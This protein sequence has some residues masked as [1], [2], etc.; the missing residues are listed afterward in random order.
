MFGSMHE[1]SP[2]HCSDYV[3]HWNRLSCDHNINGAKVV[4]EKGVVLGKRLVY[5]EREIIGR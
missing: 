5:V 1:E 3:M 2:S 4:P